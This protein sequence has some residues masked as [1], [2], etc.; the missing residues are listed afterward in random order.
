MAVFTLVSEEEAAAFIEPLALGK[1]TSLRGVPGG[2][3]NTNYFVTTNAGEF[4]LTL[5]ERLSEAQL[6]FSLQL[7]LHLARKDIPVP[8][9]RAAENGQI[10]SR[11][12]GKAACV[13]TKL[14][15]HH[16]LVPER[17]HC[18]QVGETLACM[19]Q[20]GNDFELERVNSRGYDWWFR[21]ADRI[22]PFL[23]EERRKVLIDELRFQEELAS[24]SSYRGL[25]R[26][27]VHGD[28]FRDNVLFS[29]AASLETHT[30]A[31]KLSGC[32]D[33]YFAGTDVLI[34]D[35]AV[36]LNDWCI[37]RQTGAMLPAMAAALVEGYE[38]ARALTSTERR[39]LP[40]VLRAAALR[41]WLSRLVDLHFPRDSA[42]LRAH[43]PEHFFRVL[44]HHRRSSA[45]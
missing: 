10:V 30:V 21:A 45:F 2:I 44:C 6:S 38:R 15:G 12:S 42:L 28:L 17:Y 37:D 33:F 1:L 41:F 32:F 25:P 5:F 24:C 7:M 43:D 26:G 29:K 13:V 16:C 18:E 20:A 39:Y 11:L 31:E 34:F 22:V 23:D 27:P 9:P 19:H 36:C 3:E 40:A 4:V 8:E 14:Q 35:V